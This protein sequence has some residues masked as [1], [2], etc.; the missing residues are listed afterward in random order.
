MCHPEG[1]ARQG[2]GQN[3]SRWVNPDEETWRHGAR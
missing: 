3:R 1:S 2:Y